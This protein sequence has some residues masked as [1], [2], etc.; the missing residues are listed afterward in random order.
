M[1]TR[2]KV[3]VVSELY[4]PEETSTGHYMTHIAEGL[5][6]HF[7]VGVI[8]CQPTYAARGTQA[9]WKETHNGVSIERCRATTL[10]KNIIPL[11]LVNLA[12]ISLSVFLKT[13]QRLRRGDVALVVTNPPL[14]PFL[15]A[16]ACKVRGAKCIL[17]IDDTYPEI[18]LATGMAKPGSLIVRIMRSASRMLYENVSHIT[19]LGRDMALLVRSRSRLEPSHVT[20]V[21]NWADLDILHPT[22]K[23]DNALL[24]ELGLNDKF[25]VQCAGNMGRAQNIEAMFA[26]AELL[27]NQDHIHFLFI[28]SGAKVHWMHEEVERKGLSN[29]TILGQQPRSDQINFL[30]AC[31]VSLVSLV[32]NMLGVSVPS[33]MYNVMAVGKPII[34]I[35]DAASELAQVVNEEKIG[36]VTSP[37]DPKAIANAILDAYSDSTRLVEMGKRARA[38]AESKYSTDRAVAAYTRVVSKAL[39]ISKPQQSDTASAL[40]DNRGN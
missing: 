16:V 6:Q 40:Q 7:P 1:A 24:K 9:P 34:V 26:A 14:L 25:V 18:L 31:D 13:A 37:D 29:V 12:T 39:G 3:W 11:R 36:W 23:A 17:K 15:V 2:A 32:P 21:P 33:R 27:K 30:N 35:A 22:S 4:Y 28:G 19:V 8:C 20:V 38:A 10:N 5:A